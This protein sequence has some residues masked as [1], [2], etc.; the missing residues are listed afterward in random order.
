MWGKGNGTWG[1]GFTGTV[2]RV[3]NYVVLAFAAPLI[4]LL[5]ILF[6]LTMLCSVSIGASI[7]CTNEQRRTEQAS[8]FLPDCRA[9]ELVSQPNQPAPSYELYFEGN[10][11]A[12][13]THI[14]NF[15]E[16]PND[17]P[18]AEYE[19]STALDGNAALF[20]SV[21]PNSEGDGIKAN[22]SRRGPGGW[23][24][25]N[26][27]PTRSRTAF[28]CN[29]AY[30]TGFTPNLDE[31][32][33]NIGESE[34]EG[35]PV[36]ACGH[37]EPP[38]TPGESEESANA[39]LRDTATR[40]FQLINLTPPG[41][42]SYDP[43]FDAVSSDGSH[44]VFQSRAQLTTDAP[45]GEVVDP[46]LTSE[47]CTSDFGNVYVW[48]QGVV[49][50]LSVLPAGA[51]VRGTLAG[52]HPSECGSAPSQSAVFTHSVSADGE[53][54]L[55]Y[56]GGG[57]KHPS[58]LPGEKVRPNAPYID[59]GLY[60]REH[61]SVDQSAVNGSGECT[62]PEKACTV[63]IDV[64]Q[65]GLGNSGNGQ[66]QWAS[67]ET[68]KIFF[69]D[70]E[71]LTHG[72]TAAPGKPDLYEY[73]LEKPRGQRL[74]DVT[75]NASEPADVLGVSGASEDGSY[76]YFVAQSDLTGAQQNSQGATALVPA[77]GTGEL[78]GG[79]N[80]TG[81]LILGSN[82]VTNLTVTSGG[83]FVGQEFEVEGGE[84]LP[85]LTTVTACAPSCSAPTE[86]TLSKT[87]N[88]SK[89]GASLIGYGHNQVTSVSVTSGDFA[90][91]MAITGP[92][93]RPQTWIT[94]VGSGTLTLSRG[95]A[96][97][98]SGTQALS[99]TAANL[100]MR[101]AGATT[102]IASL[103]AEGGDQCDWTAICLTS[104]VSQNGAFLAFDSLDSLTG[105][106][107]HPVHPEACRHL[108]EL[109]GD[110]EP[111]CMEAFRY[112]AASAPHGELTC[113][114][115]NPSGAPPASEFAYA[116][117]EQVSREGDENGRTMRMDHP[118]SDSG[119]VFFDTMEKLVPADK[120]GTWDVYEYEG[121]EGPSA[122]LH[123]ISTGKSEQPSYFE[124]A[125]ADGSNVFFVTFQS[126]LRADTRTDYDLY[127]A[128]IGGGF[129]SQSKRVQPPKCES[130]ESLES[131]HPPLSE[132]P[133]E[134]SA[135][136][137]ALSG[138]GNLA[139]APGQPGVAPGQPGV[140]K[141]A[142]KLT[143]KQQLARALKACTMR[144]RHKL[145]RRHLCE[146]QAHTRYGAK[147]S[148]GH[149]RNGRAGK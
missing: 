26:I 130:L 115:C 132:P 25:E 86:L 143:R 62:E 134:F 109:N 55:F 2:S 38:L 52:A 71:K 13:E 116:V 114:S 105:Y 113:A 3:P 120:N 137:A 19:I 73:D 56:A 16:A 9:F 91:G 90:V 144:Y 83:F 48:S 126:L 43:H 35:S 138:A 78:A 74:T 30:S 6:S 20:A 23:T 107:N 106:D 125:S 72:S 22:L 149:R 68:S 8:T 14:S 69:T 85:A 139:A 123:L 128:R 92:G 140:T 84:D 33:I 45:N 63:Q 88:K 50:L 12:E 108:T 44:V 60:L 36:D 98:A 77:Q 24:G 101:H 76:V 127:D 122:Q 64:K 34:G 104:R 148:R 5:A 121:G 95:V 81:N 131:C 141:P 102:F 28:L 111:P 57:F 142:K 99:A 67:A 100:Y 1:S 49:H 136:S 59:G 133:A 118:V 96:V 29:S 117:I 37:A 58:P 53:R 41:K 82:K 54:M 75:A 129:V 15:G 135:A 80:G 70:E 110:A 103:N 4:V 40:S 21:Q 124:G 42:T 46:S 10:P 27:I 89:P 94:S 93:I 66:F 18:E 145:K 39:F 119:Q 31:I 87:A 51:P 7:G 17:L 97:T 11:P 65:G 146:R 47:H 79:S 32:A 147:A 112:A 61:P